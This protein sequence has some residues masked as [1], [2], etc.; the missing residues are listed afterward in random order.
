MRIVRARWLVAGA[1]LV[2]FALGLR[3]YHHFDRARVLHPGDRLTPLALTTLS[4][5]PVTLAA[6]ASRPQVINIFATWC[7]PCRIETPGFAL[8]AKRLEERGIQVVGIDQQEAP[9]Q[10]ARFKSAFGL[11]YPVYIDS[12][13]LTHS[14]L[15]ARMIPTTI[16]IG[17][18]GV[19][20]WVHPGPMS[21]EDLLTLAGAKENAG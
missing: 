5:G 13:G 14:V 15:G 6:P 4:G 12:N 20:K 17:A 8:A 3:V 9:E 10:V 11:Q 21:A 7:V 1:A 16:F 19:I 2:A 18:D